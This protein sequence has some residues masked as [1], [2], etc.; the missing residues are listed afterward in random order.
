MKI[1]VEVLNCTK[2]E[3]IFTFLSQAIN[4]KPM[5]VED[6]YRAGIKANLQSM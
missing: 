4:R 3:A 1:I 6:M 2:E 5:T